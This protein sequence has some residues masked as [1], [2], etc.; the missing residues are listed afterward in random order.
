[1]RLLRLRMDTL[2][3]TSGKARLRFTQ[4]KYTFYTKPFDSVGQKIDYQWYND[5]TGY[6]LFR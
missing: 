6:L 1:M 4:Y 2:K 5:H 3:S